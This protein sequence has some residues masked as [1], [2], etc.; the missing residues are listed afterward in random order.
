LAFVFLLKVESVELALQI[1]D[2]Y[3]VRGHTIHVERA[4]F[5]MKGSFDPNK[6]RKKLTNKEKKKL[7]EKQQK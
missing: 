3:D 7:K 6:K 5:T 4:K 2:G 1:L